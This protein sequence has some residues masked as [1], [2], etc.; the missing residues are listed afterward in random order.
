MT[1]RERVLRAIDREGPD[2]MPV[3]IYAAPGGLY[4][5]G[6]KM[7]DH[8]RRYESDFGDISGAVIRR[9]SPEEIEA[10]GRYRAVRTDEWG[11]CWEHTVFGAWGIPRQRPLDDWAALKDFRAPEP[12]PMSGPAFDEA[13]RRADEH[14]KRW[15]LQGG[16]GNVFEIMHSLRRFEDVLMEIHDSTDE[17]NELAD[18][19]FDFR[20]KQVE[21]ALALGVDGVA[22]GDDY[23]T[24]EALI[25][26][27]PVWRR[28]FKPRYERL[29]APVREAG[30]N[31][32]FHSCGQISHLLHDLAELGVN[33]IWPQLPL[34]DLETLRRTCERLDMAVALH[35][36]RAHT[37]CFGSPDDVRRA[38]QQA[39]EVFRRP[40]GGAWWYI[41]IECGFP[42]ENVEALFEATWENR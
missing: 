3:E 19:I 7:L 40:E 18:I 13:K 1:P 36:D 26:S 30:R 31:I 11:I 12:P 5:H 22:F 39:A 2:R 41:E 6:E 37:M 10:D 42:W 23:G 8:Y 29:M 28:F 33:S 32:H 24:Q 34:Y 17:I 20:L 16:A 35:V 9:P 4:E 21:H 15:Y 38:V 27:L 14:K 25:M